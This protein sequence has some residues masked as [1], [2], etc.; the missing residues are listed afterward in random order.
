MFSRRQLRRSLLFVCSLSIIIVVCLMV[1]RDSISPSKFSTI[2]DILHS[3]EATN[4]HSNYKHDD[5][6][7]QR[8]PYVTKRNRRRYSFLKLNKTFVDI[9]PHQTKLPL[10][11]APSSTVDQFNN[12]KSQ[13]PL[14]HYKV[15]QPKERPRRLKQQEL[16]RQEDEQV[17]KRLINVDISH[18]SQLQP[19]HYS[20]TQF[21]QPESAVASFDTYRLPLKNANILNMTNV[22]RFVHLDLKGAAPK[23]DYFK[24]LF[25]LL[26]KLG[27]SGL[28]IEYEDMFPFKGNLK[29]V[30]HGKHYTETDIQQLLQAAKEN[31][32][33]IM[34]LL[35][36]YGHLEYVL[37][38]KEFMHLREDRRYPQVISPCLQESYTVLF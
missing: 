31:D 7:H 18:Q 12:Q 24:Q 1:F 34:P 20:K 29:S 38:L 21:K 14:S 35:Q 16:G 10:T 17:N 32:L 27:A 26:K 23:I 11:L 25:P 15:V 2:D 6:S 4:V 9:K 30:V 5:H 36:T 22:E 28:L 8:F 37:K 13:T 19:N 33:K 3:Q